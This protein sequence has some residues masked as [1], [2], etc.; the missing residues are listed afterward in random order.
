MSSVYRL[1]DTFW[2]RLRTLNHDT[3]SGLDPAPEPPLR[4]G[5]ILAASAMPDFAGLPLE[6]WPGY[7]QVDEADQQTTT[8]A[9]GR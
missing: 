4:F 6:F 1:V 5:E 2:K 3:R 8:I 9:R 7:R